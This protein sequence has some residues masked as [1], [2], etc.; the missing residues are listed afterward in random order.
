MAQFKFDAIGTSWQIDVYQELSKSDEDLL[1]SC[2]KERIDIFDKN[3]SR[4]RLD[5]LVMLMSQKEGDYNMPEDSIELFNIYHDIY[6]RTN[7]LVTPLIG[8]LISDAG[9]DARYSLQQKKELIMPPTWEEAIDFQFPKLKIKKPVLLDFGAAGKGY[10]VDIV[11]K[12]IEEK[13]Y[14]SYCVDAG[15]DIYYKGNN[16]IKIGL[17]NPENLDEVIGVYNLQDSQS[18]CGSAG[19]RRVWNNFTHIINPVTLSSPVNI[20]AVWVIADNTVIAD[21]LATCLFFVDP[22]K[23]FDN[24]KFEYLIVFK[25]RSFVKSNNFNG[26]VFIK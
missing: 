4:F 26:E 22:S 19:N 14:K 17:E 13:G 9:Y 2:I 18:I 10:L 6:I 1:F 5:S 8:N 12:L 16:Q 25:D 7:G 23:F 11:S 21:A 20:S 3:Y 15:G 24:Y